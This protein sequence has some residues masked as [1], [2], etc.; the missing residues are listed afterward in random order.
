MDDSDSILFSQPRLFDN[1]KLYE[2]INFSLLGLLKRTDI[3]IN[4]YI[5]NKEVLDVGCGP[6]PYFY[7]PSL[8]SLH[9]GIDISMTFLKRSSEI[10]PVSHF[11]KASADNLP[12]SDDSFDVVLLLFTLHHIPVDHS[13][14]IKEANRVSRETIIVF[15]HNQSSGGFRKILKA[16]WWKFKDKGFRYNTQEEWGELLKGYSVLEKKLLGGF[17]ENI[18]EFIILKRT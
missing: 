10:L 12:F 15:D 17:L 13:I 9:C 4:K 3:D 2:F 8:A 7:D 14:L 1:Q 5:K 18:F 11:A 6:K 16:N